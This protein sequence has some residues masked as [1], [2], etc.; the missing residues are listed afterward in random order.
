VRVVQY[1]DL[2]KTLEVGN[3]CFGPGAHRS[4]HIQESTE[5]LLHNSA[6]FVWHVHAVEGYFSK[7]QMQ[8]MQK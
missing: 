1:Q 7:L 6:R 4:F 2:Y 5:P 3:Q 8:E